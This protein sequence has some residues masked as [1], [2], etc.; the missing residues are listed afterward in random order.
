MQFSPILILHITGGMVGLL[1]GVAAMTFPKGSRWHGISGQVFV[2]SML[3]MSSAAT[4]LAIVK[5]QSG[6]ILGGVFTFYLVLTAWLTARRRDAKPGI[7]DWAALVIVAPIGVLVLSEGLKKALGIVHPDGVPTGMNFFLGSIILLAAAGDIRMLKRGGIFGRQRIVRHLWRMCFGFFIATGS[8]F[9]SQA[10]K[11]FPVLK[12]ERTVLIVPAILPLLLLIFWLV[13]VRFTNLYERK[14]KS[15]RGSS[16]RS[17]RESD[18]LP[19]L[20]SA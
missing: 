13:R 14:L 1:S 11:L 4:Y 5:H 7:F 18:Y 12:T 15:S 20:R 6:N 9:L 8:F 17:G 10:F 19:Q 3:V 2:V 16:N